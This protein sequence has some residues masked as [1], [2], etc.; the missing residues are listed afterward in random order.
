MTLPTEMVRVAPAPGRKAPV[1]FCKT[2]MCTFNL[3]GKCTRGGRCTYAHSATE[4]Q[5][6]PD[7]SRTKMCAKGSDCKN[8]SCGYAHARNELRH[9]SYAKICPADGHEDH[10]QRSVHVGVQGVPYPPNKLREGQAGDCTNNVQKHLAPAAATTQQMELEQ[11]ADLEKMLKWLAAIH[12]SVSLMY[13]FGAVHQLKNE[14]SH[15]DR[16][17]C[18]PEQETSLLSPVQAP[19]KQ[20]QMY[21]DEQEQKE[22]CTVVVKNTFLHTEPYV[23][24]PMRLTKTVDCLPLVGL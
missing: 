20:L 1:M 2:K 24:V 10:G 17:A 3:L 6:A 22:E 8:P 11:L 4:L 9:H 13:T 14:I 21:L 7:F 5:A 15:D 23:S 16:H 19:H 18:A 12:Q